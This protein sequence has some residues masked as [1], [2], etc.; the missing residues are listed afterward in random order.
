MARALDAPS[1]S[2]TT[3][4]TRRRS[5]GHRLPLLSLLLLLRPCACVD[6][7][8]ELGLRRTATQADIKAAYRDLAKRYHPDKNKEPG[9]AERFQRLSLIH[10]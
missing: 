7:Y 3:S 2:S 5:R 6:Y 10:I 4:T 1:S 8:R 9:S